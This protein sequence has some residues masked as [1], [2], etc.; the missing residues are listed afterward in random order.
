MDNLFYVPYAPC[1]GNFVN[2]KV[3]RLPPVVAYLNAMGREMI[4]LNSSKV[5]LDLLGKKSA[6]Y[7][8]HPAAMMCGEIIG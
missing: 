8:D 6:T 1:F 7:S 5:T 2:N 4:I 3:Y